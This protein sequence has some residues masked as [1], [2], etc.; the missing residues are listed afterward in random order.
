MTLAFDIKYLQKCT[1][2]EAEVK[3][4]NHL[5]AIFNVTRK[6]PCEEQNYLITNYSLITVTVKSN[7]N[8]LFL[9]IR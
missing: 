6:Q 9:I 5:Q 8:E 1:V 7:F 3:L 2:N 4:L